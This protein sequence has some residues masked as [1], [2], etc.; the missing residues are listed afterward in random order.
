MSPRLGIS[1]LR[2]VTS[3]SCTRDLSHQSTD[4]DH[5]GEKA[6]SISGEQQQSAVFCGSVTEGDEETSASALTETVVLDLVL[7]VGFIFPACAN[8]AILP[9]ASFGEVSITVKEAKR[10]S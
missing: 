4:I 8:V 7:L 10:R 6:K 2:G 9:L 5:L 1:R 3:W